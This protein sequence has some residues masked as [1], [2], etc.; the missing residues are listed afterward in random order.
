MAA[1]NTE[2]LAANLSAAMKAVGDS[3]STLA[4]TAT[5]AIPPLQG[6]TS[7]LKGMATAAVSAGNA[8]GILLQGLAKLAAVSIA[9]SFAMM[10]A[11]DQ[12]LKLP[13]GVLEKSIASVGSEI[14]RVVQLAQPGV[15]KL[16]EMAIRDLYASIGIALIPVME[17]ATEIFRTIGG[18][19][20]GL[21]ANGQKVIQVL[22]VSSVA[23]VSLGAV[24][25]GVAA[26]A[27]AG[28]V[29]IT[30]LSA[31]IAILEAVASGGA[32]IPVLAAIGASL[33]ALGTAGGAAAGVMGAVSAVMLSIT[34]VATDLTPIL[35]QLAKTFMMFMDTLGAA[36]KTFSS[37]GILKEIATLLDG[38]AK[39]VASLIAELTPAFG[40]FIK[41]L[42][43]LM[44]V[45]GAVVKAI[46]A[47]TIE[48]LLA[49]FK[50]LG[51]VLA[52]VGPTIDA[53]AKSF[54]TVFASLAT[55][56]ADVAK[57]IGGLILAPVLVAF[58]ALGEVMKVVGPVLG[59]L[60]KAF[61]TVF[62][63]IMG[64]AG[65]LI[66]GAAKL[67][68]ALAQVFA[69]LAVGPIVIAF[70]ILGDVFKVVGPMVEAFATA[71]GGIVTAIAG[72][73]GGLAGAVGEGLSAFTQAVS[74]LVIGF[75]TMNPIVQLTA[76]VVTTLGVAMAGLA[77]AIQDVVTDV[78]GGISALLGLTNFRNPV[79]AAAGK[80][81]DNTGAAATSATT[82][83]PRDA[84]RKARESAFQMGTG[85]AK[86][87]PAA[88][89]AK[90]T[91]AML[92][93]IQ[94]MR[95]AF[96]NQ[97]SKIGTFIDNLPNELKNIA[98]DTVAGVA[99]A[100]VEGVKSVFPNVS[101]PS[102]SDIRKGADTL[103]D[104][105]AKDLDRL[106]PDNPFK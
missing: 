39:T 37:S 83:D 86:E 7:A 46:A 4:A 31:A 71:F 93:E 62:S 19:I 102:A 17:K 84:L 53:F 91:N 104:T 96:N 44:P 45:V 73:V 82:G 32:M 9:T 75:A 59:S 65:T 56:F 50:V 42:G 54:A 5:G 28:A 15:F 57:A 24:L 99:T 105:I 16:F 97:F 69:S 90:N 13:L 2:R 74:Q 30:A 18:A 94:A 72:L 63:S 49:G 40:L 60:A 6:L 98:K 35:N 76:K 11:G 55:T 8:I 20:Y 103:V 12:L 38:F 66:Q 80:P 78:I 33:T 10:A 67:A 101:T 61:A 23:F 48:P 79:T 14:G 88:A 22:A 92:L 43:D 34:A 58:Q 95:A 85:G 47:V 3:F 106:I 100:V 41:I 36:F 51:V 27:V 70:K 81:P 25:A 21:T 87:D 29:A 77:L 68:G 52:A 26:L 1:G 64:G 89:T